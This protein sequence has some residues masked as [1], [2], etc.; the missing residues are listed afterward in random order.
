[1]ENDDIW[2]LSAEEHS[3]EVSAQLDAKSRLDQKLGLVGN[4]SMEANYTEL[5]FLNLTQVCGC[6][7]TFERNFIL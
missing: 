2:Q 6:K 3:F 7:V 5:I 1:M 4:K